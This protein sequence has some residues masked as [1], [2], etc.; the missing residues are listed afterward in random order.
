MRHHCTRE[1]IQMNTQQSTRARIARP[2]IARPRLARPVMAGAFLFAAAAA[3]A[4]AA[5]APRA[6]PSP[7]DIA[8]IRA[9]PIAS[10]SVASQTANIPANWRYSLSPTITTA[11]HA[12]V[13][14]DAPLATQ[15]GLDILKQGG[16]AIDAAVATA[17]A[18]AV[19]YPEAGNVG[20]GG[21][22]VAHLANGKNIA[23][24][25]R[26]E[27]PAGAT[28][29]MFLDAKGAVTEASVTGHRASGVPGSV[30][31]LWAAHGKYGKL[32]WK[33]LLAPAIRLARNGFTVDRAFS[34]SI[35]GEAARLQKFDASAALFL[36]D[37][38][39]PTPGS[40]FSNPELAAV[41]QRIADSGADGFYKGETA[42][43]IAAEMRRGGGL[44]TM[45]DLAHYRA[46]WREPGVFDYR[47]HRIIA[48]PPATSG[49]ITLALIAN[50]LEGYPL[51]S[52]GWHSA[53][54]LHVIAEA[55]RRAFADRNALLGDPDF[56]NVQQQRLTSQRYAD[57]LRA[58]IDLAH[59]T[60]SSSIR[61]GLGRT[62]EPTHT[63]HFSIV[64][65]AGNALAMTTTINDLFG[66]AVTVRGA[67]IVL[68]DEMDDFTSKP[69]E[70][71]MY[72]LVQGTA[73][74]IQP[75][76]R[77]LSAMTPTIVLDTDGKVML[78]TGARGGPHIIT[79]V[80][81]VILNVIDYGFDVG[82]AVDAPRIHH[83]HLPD[84]IL[85]E[86]NGLSAAV[87]DSLKARGHKVNSNGGYVGTAPTILRRNGV[88]TAVP[89]PRTGGLALGN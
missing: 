71:N 4:A 29:D 84:E 10:A 76:K 11:P 89:D 73:N 30:A 42:R 41:L 63:T 70:P 26:E 50:T 46:K 54:S 12:M 40:Q 7:R 15:V 43:L 21:F 65:A 38:K 81:Q 66:S 28:R 37:G 83:Q 61:P 75:G 45:Q 19:V 6:I 74:A 39:A 87:I 88:W 55:M 60:P 85:A 69:G 34:A 79:A 62:P 56:V 24:D 86:P 1:K 27:A 23:L 22:I 49:G 64:D 48:M 16:N 58:T 68:N 80:A 8:N 33:T 67:G 82:A 78:V 77:M 36:H 20:G 17:F 3:A 53:A 44:I 59:A 25:F 35:I 52:M 57:S 18:L 14:T 2:R 72:G 5:C 31:G 47:G 9:N 51:A 32:P 13:V